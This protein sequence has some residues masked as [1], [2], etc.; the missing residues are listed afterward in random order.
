MRKNRSPAK[1]APQ[2]APFDFWGEHSRIH[3]SGI[4][5]MIKKKAKKKTA[6]KEI[7]KAAKKKS[8][9]KRK[10][11]KKDRDSKDV[12]QDCSKLVKEDATELT[13]A[14]IE[15]GKKGQLGPV[16]YL[17][18]M[19]SIFPA[20]DDGSQ[21]SAKEESFA[22]TLLHRLG[23]PTDPV[24]ADQYEKEDQEVISAK[25]SSDDEDREVVSR[26]EPG[27]KPEQ[28]SE[29]AVAADVVVSG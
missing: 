29:V 22:E 19:A 5:A 12:R 3:T 25:E 9:A 13:A 23:I 26:K 17:F 18:E 27:A 7:K 11:S 10:G 24:V 20:A 6:A 21:A 1:G 2:S 28:N 15:E 8:T 16:K 4:G 14:V